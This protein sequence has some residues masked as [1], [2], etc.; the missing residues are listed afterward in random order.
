[1]VRLAVRSGTYLLMYSTTAGQAVE[2]NKRFAA[3]TCSASFAALSSRP[4]ML[5]ETSSAPRAVSLTPRKP[6]RR[7]AAIICSRE[8]PSNS[9]IQEGASET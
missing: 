6:R 9:V 7:M 3:E 8:T 1:M 5:A 2:M 4:A